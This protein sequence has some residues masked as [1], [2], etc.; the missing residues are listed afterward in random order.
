MKGK[1]C[2]GFRRADPKTTKRIVQD[3]PREKR[4]M[5][6]ACNTRKCQESK[7]RG[8]DTIPEQVRQSLLS[9]NEL[10]FEKEVCLQHRG[11]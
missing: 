5:A 7:K 6:L 1:A 10:G 9:H 3:V 11:Y 2:M 8:G 4:R